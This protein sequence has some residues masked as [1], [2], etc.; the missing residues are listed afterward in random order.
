MRT[1]PERVAFAPTLF[2]LRIMLAACLGQRKSSYSGKNITMS[3]GHDSVD[4]LMLG[5]G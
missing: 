4:V 3:S 5:A 2:F 1:D